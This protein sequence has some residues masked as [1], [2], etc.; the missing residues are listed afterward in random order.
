MT[1]TAPTAAQVTNRDPFYAEFVAAETRGLPAGA[2]VTVHGGDLGAFG[3]PAASEHGSSEIVSVEGQPFARAVRVTVHRSVHPP[4]TVQ[5]T[6]PHSAAPVRKGDVLLLIYHVRC[7]ASKAESGGGHAQG[8][9]QLTRDPWTGTGSFGAAPGRDWQK[10]YVRVVSQ[11]DYGAGELEVTFHLG[12]YAQTLEFGGVVLLGLGPDVDLKALPVSPVTY[13]GRGL[14]APWRDEA[15]Q[16]IEQHRKASLTV[17]VTDDKGRPVPD[18]TVHVRMTRHA[19]QF[20][21]FLERPALWDSADGERYRAE[22]KRLFNRVTCPLYWADWGWANAANRKDYLDL[23]QWA[24]DGGFHIRGHNLIWP[25]WRWTPSALRRHENDPDA[26]GRAIR[27]SIVER[28]ELF[29]RF[30]FEDYD[31]INELRDNHEI[32]DILG[33]PVIAEWHKLAA[34]LHPESRMGVNEYSII[35]GGGHT[36]EQQEIYEE[37]IRYL[38]DQGAPVQVIGFQCHIGEDM[39]P[40][41]QVVKI[42]DRFARQGVPL[43]ATEF[44]ISTDDEAAQGD[45]MRDFLTVFFSHP[46]T[47]AITQWGFWEGQHWIP[48]AALFRKDWSL[49]P[50]GQAYV[51]LVLNAWWTD[52]EAH[53]DRAGEA[54]VRAFKGTHRVTVS[55][56]GRTAEATAE[57]V[58][59]RDLVVRLTGAARK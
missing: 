49:K 10:R 6:T 43:H 47:E 58:R 3:R 17:R 27:E 4:W 36:E 41:G 56:G 26:L 7:L 14:D 21:T 59:D 52:M 33:R 29:R 13:V 38:R 23:A 22:T 31:V 20:G 48:R 50:N 53:T 37:Q 46:A 44:D 24:F 32:V 30:G 35:A 2:A 51:D 28:M 34:R 25:S 42:L 12:R 11:H 16:R 55:A 15:A 39:T 9:L 5:L 18:A 57:V 45:Y 40:P 1:E 19:Y 8:F 54:V